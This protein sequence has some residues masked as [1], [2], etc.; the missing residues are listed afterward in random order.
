MSYVDHVQPSRAMM[1]GRHRPCGRCDQLAWLTVSGRSVRRIPKPRPAGSV[2]R[3]CSI[4]S[5]KAER[6]AYWTRERTRRRAQGMSFSVSPRGDSGG[7]PRLAVPKAPGISELDI[8]RA[9]NLLIRQHGDDAEIE[10]ARRADRMLDRGNRDG[11]LVWLRV[12]K[13]IVALQAPP[14]GPPH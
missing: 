2:L 3:G 6:S 10:A 8:W 7:P 1:P 4:W 14:S 5:K 12:L 9:A 13:A 11:Q